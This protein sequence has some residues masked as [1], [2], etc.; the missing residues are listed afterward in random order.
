MK[1]I[2]L[3]LFLLLITTVAVAQVNYYVSS[4]GSDINSGTFATPW[5][6]IQYGINHLNKNDTL[7]LL[8]GTYTEKIIV[9]KSNIYIR[10]HVLNTPVLVGTGITSQ[11]AMITISDRSN[12]TIDGLEISNNIQKDAQGILVDGTGNKITIQNC[13]IHD[14]HFSA[15]PNAAVNSGTN[16]QGIIVY[17]SNASTPVTNLKISNNTLFNCRLGYSEGIAVNGN[18]DGFEI[19]H[20]LVHDITNIGIDAIGHEGT[21]PNAGNDQARNGLI[22]HNVAHHC[23]SPYATSGGIYVDGGKN[24]IIEN[25]LSFHNG[26]GIEIGCENVGKTTDSIIVRNNIFYDNE[27]AAIAMGG[28]EYPSGS[29]KVTHAIIRNNTCFKDDFKNDGN[30]E[31][32]LSYS[33]N[34]IIENN[35]FYLSNQDILAYSERGQPGLKFDY[36]IFY[37]DNDPNNFETDWN[38]SNYS[39]FSAF[40][41]GTGTNNNSKVANPQLVNAIL[42]N[43]DFHLKNTSPAI[44]AGNPSFISAKTEMDIDLQQRISGI[45]DCGAD[46]YWAANASYTFSGNG[47]WTDANN[48]T[49]KIIPPALLT[50]NATIIIDPPANGACILDREQQIKAGAHLIIQANKK[51][52]ITGNLTTK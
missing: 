52:R 31:L 41:A 25:N 39:S 3:L 24:I 9:S 7:N 42:P 17:G 28:Y 11:D 26:Y 27:I 45:V 12:V 51:F 44:D 46:E 40:K 30:G 34:S 33:E 35:I 2:H 19:S 32:Y 38:N 15:N 10:N 1:K 18:V 5:K 13:T 6:T 47:N 20:N 48:W 36:N 23:I 29:G 22:M 37:S 16:A 49:N 8:S 4:A 21:S 14:I 43:P 50:G